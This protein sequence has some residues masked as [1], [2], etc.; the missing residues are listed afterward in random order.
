M[1]EPAGNGRAQI[2]KDSTQ[3]LASTVVA[4]GTAL[5]RAILLPVLLLPAQLGV[6]NL[7]NVVIGYGANAHL[8]ILHGFNKIVPSLR[9]AGAPAE[10]DELKDSV[11]WANLLLGLSA[12]IALIAASFLV[13]PMYAHALRITALVV[14]LQ[15]VFVFYFSLLRAENRFGLV[16]K[17]IAGFSIVSS[18]TVLLTA[19]LSPDRLLGA[20]YG[21]AGAYPFLLLYWYHKGGYRFTACM[22]WSRVKDAFVLGFPLIILG[23]MDMVL[24]SLDRWIIA[25]KFTE[26]SLGFYAIGIMASNL[27][28]MVP[29]S[30]A[31]VLYPRMLEQYAAT[32]DYAA[33]GGLL[34][35]PVRAMAALMI[36]LT[37][38]AAIFVPMV[39]RLFLPQYAPSIPL[40]EILVPGAYFLA[41]APIAGCYVVAVNL[42]RAL[43]AVQVVAIVACLALYGVFLHAGYGVEGI[44]YGTLCCYAVYGLGY[45]GI[46]VYLA[47]GKWGDT[48]RFLAHLLL[49]FAIM[50]IALTL[51]ASLSH[52]S[53]AWKVQASGAFLRLF[54]VGVLVTPVMWLVNR[55]SGIL[56]TL[57]AELSCWRSSRNLP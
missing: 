1:T 56:S 5:L 16:S 6:W 42:Q 2:L 20:L 52:P 28:G 46:A 18:I 12:G 17:G 40:I 48:L 26:A 31:N 13:Q 57:L 45:M 19:Y 3:Y 41:I 29:T 37:A 32:K 49:P 8:G 35:N 43:I 4:Q 25:W 22:N 50:V 7:M 33:V 23:A 10:L 21:C 44:A 14:V 55:N 53:S 36:F 47:R 24:L 39:I 51:T 27:L 54:A 15:I 30:A 9:V 11:F 38:L 34:L